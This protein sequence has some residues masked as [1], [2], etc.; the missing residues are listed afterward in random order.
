ML[1]TL[2]RSLRTLWLSTLAADALSILARGAGIVTA[3]LQELLTAFAFPQQALNKLRA[4]SSELETVVRNWE[5]V[6]PRAE[7]PVN[8]PGPLPPG[9]TH[10]DFRR[11]MREF[12]G[13]GGASSQ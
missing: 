7:S 12:R 13:A 11:L 6:P 8:L 10:E 4:V 9:V 3:E 5:P 2:W 1:T